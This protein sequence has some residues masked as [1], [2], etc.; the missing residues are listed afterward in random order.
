MPRPTTS[1][2]SV[3]ESTRRSGSGGT[4]RPPASSVAMNDG[5][6]IW[7]KTSLSSAFAKRAGSSA[8]DG[9]TFRQPVAI[10][11]K[12]SVLAGALP[13]IS[14]SWLPRAMYH[15]TFRPSAVNAFCARSSSPG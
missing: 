10:E 4:L 8:A 11:R 5:S 13:W 14:P 1:L 9:K 7:R 2:Y 15:G 12:R 6:P 3:V